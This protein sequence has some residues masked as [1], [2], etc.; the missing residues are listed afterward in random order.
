MKRAAI[1]HYTDRG[2]ETARRIAA[3]LDKEWAVEIHRSKCD[4]GELFA[5][6]DALI[7]VGACGIA[8]RAIAPHLRGK[9]TDPAVIVADERG[10]NVISLLSG[11]IGGA[12][13][14]TRQIAAAIGAN[15]VI[16]TA[17]DV[18]QRF[19]VDEWAARN[20]LRIQSMQAAKRF[21]MEILRQ[22]LPLASDFPVQGA[23]PSG[24]VWGEVGDCGLLISCKD[25]APFEATLQLIPKI[26]HLGVG[27]KRDTSEEKIEDAVRAALESAQL[28]PEAIR[29][30]ASI[31]VKQDE[32]GL[33]AFAAQRQIPAQFYG[34]A[35]L[36][37]LEGDFSASAFVRSAVGVDNVC[38]RAAMRSA[39]AHAKLIVKKT[40]LHGVTVAVA[41][42]EWSVCFE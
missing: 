3:A 17:T 26:L 24:V 12:N 33:L 40:C 29:A 37:A 28:R 5:R 21:A 34:A 23:L 31:D 25:R 7:F 15:P 6:M 13:E 2:A 10:L 30:L 41:Q 27:C 36:A 11:H 22:D 9:T 16:T 14:C 42:E 19:A 20:G 8:V 35:E 32:A 4:V 1:L 38:E 39:G 18:N